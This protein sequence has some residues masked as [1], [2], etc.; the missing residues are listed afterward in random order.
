MKRL[1]NFSTS[2][3]YFSLLLITATTILVSPASLF[4]Q[5]DSYPPGIIQMTPKVDLNLEPVDLE[6]P[7]KFQGMVPED[8]SLNLPS[9]FTVKVFA[10]DGLRG[11]RLMA[12]TEEGVLHV[13]NMKANGSSEFQP[14]GNSSSEI[15]ALPDRNNDGVADTVIVAADGLRWANSLTF[16]KGEMYV[17]D[18]HQIVKFQD[19]DGDLVYES[20]EVFADNIPT[21]SSPHITRTI[22]VDEQKERFYLSVGSSCDVCREEDPERA[23]VLEFSAD[24]TERRIFATGLRNAIGLD[25]HPTSGDLWA[26]NNGHTEVDNTMPPEWI[27][28]VRDGGFYGWPLAFGFQVY[29]DFDFRGHWRVPPITREDSLLVQ[30]MK[31][32]AALVDAHSSPMDIHFYPDGDF[33]TDYHKAAFVAYRSGFRGP[34]PGHKVVALFVDED[35]SNASVGDFMTGFWPN[36]PDQGNIW[37]K[38]VGLTTDSEGSLYL[39]SDWINHLILKVEYQG[40][41]TSILDEGV[42]ELPLATALKQ[43]YPNPFN[44]VTTIEY[45]L[46]KSE[47]VTLE[48]FDALGRKVATLVDSYQSAGQYQVDFNA[49]KLSSGIYLYRLKAG[50]Y[51]ESKVLTLMK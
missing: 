19:Q 2:W 29:I 41:G 21:A 15:L 43:N 30:T 28:I 47:T 50:D 1:C 17:A 4:A 35:G 13:A 32:P 45:S 42:S 27:D 37:G 23:T 11:P 6:I 20:R 18:T 5:D 9:G 39:S 25:I 40:Q 31:R 44:P 33:P 51:T 14:E 36:P 16:Y 10:V 48:V 22:V 24:G 7:E 8:L 49:S 38:P 26:T 46:Q 3:F 34:D 12:F